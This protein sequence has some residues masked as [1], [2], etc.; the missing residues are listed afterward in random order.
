MLEKGHG[1]FPASAELVMESADLEASQ[2]SIQAAVSMLDRLVESR[3]ED[4]AAALF[5]LRLRAPQLSPEAY[6]A[7]LWKLFDRIPA[8]PPA[9]TALVR[10][11]IAAHDWDGALLA[12]REHR[13]AAGED[14]PF[15]LLMTGVIDAMRGSSAE[16]VSF[17]RKAADA[18]RDG[19]ARYDLALVLL[20]QGLTGEALDQL[21]EAA[22]E[23]RNRAD[24]S[25]FSVLARIEMLTG[26]ALL[27]TGDA[28]GA[29]SAFLRARALD[30]HDLR[31]GLELR[32]LEAGADQ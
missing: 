28:A 19:A 27:A 11:L 25:S 12:M 18:S 8:D 15:Q 2:G 31:I 9:F 32:K 6:R 20:N 5:R 1:F 26:T 10:S 16:A 3:P 30:P 4:S 29:R 23:A 14:D 17:L 22:G 24:G 21:A 13:A 7:E